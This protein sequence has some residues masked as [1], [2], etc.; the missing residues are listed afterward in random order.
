MVDLVSNEDDI[1]QSLHILLSTSLGER[2]M[3]PKFGCNLR[4]LL[5]E[6]LD[7][8]LQTYIRDVVEIAILYHEPRIIVEAVSV[9]TAAEE[10][11]KILISIDYH[12]TIT[13]ARSNYVY[14]FYVMEGSVVDAE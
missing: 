8:T 2:V 14:P 6:P 3:R 7:V 1:R 9:S 4:R 10:I 12:V 13:N 11:G 5:F